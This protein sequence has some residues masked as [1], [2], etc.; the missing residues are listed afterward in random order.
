MKRKTQLQYRCRGGGSVQKLS[1]P[2]AV[3]TFH[4]ATCYNTDTNN[5][6]KKKRERKK[7]VWLH[8]LRY[9]FLNTVFNQKRYLFCIPSI[10]TGFPFIAT[11]ALEITVRQ[12]WTWLKRF[13]KWFTYF[14]KWV[15]SLS[16]NTPSY[17][18]TPFLILWWLSFS[19]LCL[20]LW[21]LYSHWKR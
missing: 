16:C 3:F 21:N 19:F 12:Y 6:Q 8:I 5:G 1:K 15:I 20:K 11:K 17:F 13:G 18:E 4:K 10:E 7:R 9:L 14:R 2:D